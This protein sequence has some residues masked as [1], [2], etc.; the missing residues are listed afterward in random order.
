M[1]IDILTCIFF[2]ILVVNLRWVLRYFL[3]VKH[4]EF[5]FVWESHLS[6]PLLTTVQL[7][8]VL[9]LFGFVPFSVLISD[10]SVL[11]NL[12]L[13]ALVLSVFV[14]AYRVAN[15]LVGALVGRLM[16][17]QHMPEAIRLSMASL[18]EGHEKQKSQPLDHFMNICV[19]AALGVGTVNALGLD[20]SSLYAGLGIAV[21]VMSL[22]ANTA[23]TSVLGTVMLYSN[24]LFAVGD[25]VA[26]G[27]VS[28]RVLQISMTRTVIADTNAQIC[29]VPNSQLL[30]QT[31]IRRTHSLPMMR[32]TEWTVPAGRDSLVSR[33]LTECRNVLRH[34]AQDGACSLDDDTC[35]IQVKSANLTEATMCVLATFHSKRA[36]CVE[37]QHPFAGQTH[38]SPDEKYQVRQDPFEQDILKFTWACFASAKTLGVMS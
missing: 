34:M 20:V 29:I 23:L 6:G 26:V 25:W 4:A 31:V 38:M 13:I 35:C 3:L 30:T 36:L 32:Q 12:L 11:Q 2:I 18:K 21:I 8:V 16:S 24:D 10:V 37:R 9:A 22:V 5:A 19:F 33:W 17:S 27:A 15:L 28:G 7:G 1:L 14:L